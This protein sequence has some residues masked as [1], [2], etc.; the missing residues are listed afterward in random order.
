LSKSDLAGID[1]VYNAFYTSGP[2][3]RYSFGRGAGWQTFPTYK[4]LMTANDGHGVQR[5]Y[6]A[7]EEIYGTLRDLEERNLIVP[8]VGDF[9]G[10]KALR[11]VARYLDLHHATVSVF[12]TSNVE[13]Y[14]FRPTFPG[15]ASDA[16]QRFYDNVAAL[17]TD[18]HSTFIRAFFNNQGR[19]V[20]RG[21]PQPDPQ[22][23]SGVIPIPP[24][25]VP[26]TG[27][28]PRSETLLNPIALL[29][30][31]FAE[32]RVSTYYDVIELSR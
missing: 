3:I 18:T 29:L 6:L 28:G 31:A 19:L 12:Y 16:W 10:P 20:F 13:Q 21:Q 15:G 17:P 4:D 32:G 8:L 1:Y 22:P 25:F 26:P 14:L 2:D 30:A 7:S 27:P 23:Q 5:G 24:G 9:A 11:S